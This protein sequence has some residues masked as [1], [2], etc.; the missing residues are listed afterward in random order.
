M[1]ISYT[2]NGFSYA[3]K[4]IVNTDEAFKKRVKWMK[5]RGWTLVGQYVTQKRVG[6]YL[7]PQSFLHLRF[8]KG[9]A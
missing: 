9:V 6:T 7:T 4:V 8:K 2:S 5:Q 1:Q 3:N